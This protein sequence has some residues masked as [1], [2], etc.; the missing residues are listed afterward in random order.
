MALIKMIHCKEDGVD[1]CRD[2]GPLHKEK[3]HKPNNEEF[4]ATFP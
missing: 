3:K 4:R 1:L 2:A